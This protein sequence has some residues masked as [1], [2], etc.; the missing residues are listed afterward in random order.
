M[1][2]VVTKTV[3][4][5][6]GDYSSL[7]AAEAGIQTLYSSNFVAADVQVIVECYN[8]SDTTA[9]TIDGTTTD[10][11]RY[12]RVIAAAGNRHAGTWTTSAYRLVV[13]GSFGASITVSDDFTRLEGL[14]VQNTSSTANNAR[15]V[16]VSSIA[17]G[18]DVQVIGCILR[19]SGTGTATSAS[20]GIRAVLVAGNTLRVRNTLI[21]DS[22]NGII[23]PSG[24]S[25]VTS[26]LYNVTS[27]DNQLNGIKFDNSAHTRRW[28]N[29]LSYANATADYSISGSGTD[30]YATNL[31]GDATSPTVGLRSKTPTFVDRANDDYHLASSDTAAKDAGTDLSADANWPSRTT[32]MRSRDPARGTSAPTNTSRRAAVAARCRSP[33]SS[34]GPPNAR[35]WR[36]LRR[37]RRRMGRDEQYDEDRRLGQHHAQVEQGWHVVDDDERLH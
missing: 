29:V 32:S 27:I 12:W 1:P 19:G 36:F 28:K 23:D 4:S 35:L 2:T 11:T 31:S 10:S 34:G 20:A 25:S 5:S 30:D 21:Y 33:S 3:K 7:S 37:A 13:N 6:L 16:E 14:Q 9:V 17:S 8:F 22:G 15:M 18:A 24:N 26:M